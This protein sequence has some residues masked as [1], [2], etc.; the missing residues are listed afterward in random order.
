[1]IVSTVIIALTV[2]VYDRNRIP[3]SPGYS[4]FVFTTMI[5]GSS[6][7]HRREEPYVGHHPPH[8]DRTIRSRA[9][10]RLL[11]EPTLTDGEPHLS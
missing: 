3:T 1:M 2:T 8:T 11:S 9:F 4:R 5:R 6:V 7:L 10:R